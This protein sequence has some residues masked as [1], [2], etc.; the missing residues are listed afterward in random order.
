MSVITVSRQFASGGDEISRRV[1]EILG[2]RMFD[3]R[4]M[5]RAAIDSGLSEQEIVDFSEDNYRVRGFLDRLFNRS[6]T[7]SEARIWKEDPSGMRIVEGVK[8]SED[9]ALVLV[10][11]AIRSAHQAGNMIIIGRGG[12]VLLRD[13]P[14]VFHLR[15]IAPMEDRIQRMKTKIKTS[16]DAVPG[17]ISPRHEAQDLLNRHDRASEDYIHRFYHV[18]LDDPLLYHL[19]INTGYIPIDQGVQIIVDLVNEL[20]KAYLIPEIDSA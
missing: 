3:K 15:I 18:S 9:A 14:G 13:R 6:Q 12:Q 19:V 1:G 2:Y 4:L 11:N 16:P 20:E 7:I 5:A 8:L 17:D 10:Q